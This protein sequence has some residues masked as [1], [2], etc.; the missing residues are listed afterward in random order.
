VT[1]DIPIVGGVG[2]VL[3]DFEKLVKASELKQD[4]EALAK[5]WEQIEKWRSIECLKY[6]QNP[7]GPIKPQYVLDMLY[8]ITKGNAFVAS[9]VGQHQ[10]WAAQFY[11]FDKPRRWVNSGGL[12]TMGF[13]LPAAM[14]IQLAH[15]KAQVACVVGDGGIQMNIQELATCQQEKLPIKVICLNNGYLGMVRQW[16]EFFYEERYSEVLV[17]SQP[18]FV[19]LAESYGHVGM[20]IDNPADVEN[21]LK[22]AF[23]MKDRFV[24]L[25]FVTDPTENV[26]P[27]VPAGAGLEEMILV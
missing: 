2:N 10:M 24:F 19:K 26:Y 12:G 27:M 11:K 15:P 18:D 7:Q 21:A 3:A 6:E 14:G 25:N 5:W 13:G 22:E 23:K 4:G 1:V 9:D 20:H 17:E 8:K 16:Q